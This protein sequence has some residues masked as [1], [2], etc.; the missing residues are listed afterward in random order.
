MTAEIKKK[1]NAL[2]AVPTESVVD[3]QAIYEII[4]K[5]AYELYEKRG[6]QPGHDLE[7]WLEAEQSILSEEKTQASSTR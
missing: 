7:D 1:K 6:G 2:K 4:A 5:K 3:N